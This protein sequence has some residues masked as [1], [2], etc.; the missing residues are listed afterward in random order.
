MVAYNDFLY[1]KSQ[2]GNTFGFEPIDIPDCMFDFQKALTEWAILKGR[3]AIFAD[4]GM[5]KTLMELVWADNVVRKTNGNVL[6]LTP[7]AVSSQTIEEAAKF[8]IEASRCQDGKH[9]RGIV[10]T[11][12]ERLGNFDPANFVGVVCDESSC[13]KAYAGKT[14]KVV[15]RFMSKLRFRL[16]GTAT[17]APNDYIELGTSSEA[18][19]ELSY[20]D[21]LRRFFAQLDD[22]GQK[23]ETRLQEEAETLISS[24]PSYYQKLAYRVSQTIGQWRLKHHAVQPFWRWVA[25]WAR[26]CRMPSD[27]GFDNGDFVL[28]PLEEHDHIIS[29]A[30]P[31]AGMLFTV[32]AIGMHE[33]R[34]ERKRTLTERCEFVAN[35][36]NHNRPAAIWCNTNDEGDL[37]ADIIPDAEQIAGKTSDDRRVELYDAFR[38]G[39]LKKL[40]IKAKIGAWGLNWQ[41]C[42]HVVNFATHSYEQYYQ[43]IRRCW[44]YPQKN[45]VRLDTIA[46]VGEVRVLGNM[47]A[48]AKRADAMFQHLVAEMNEAVRIER[49][50]LYTRK[51]EV[52][53]WL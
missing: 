50:N 47:R 52:P 22:K 13:I 19:G 46:T 10:I 27:L 23:K 16:L 37:L 24:D 39:E 4:C 20:S 25:S 18:L 35:L 48:K 51:V 45:A 29:P 3:A 17:A 40:V 5:G 2:I 12:Y 32:P 6:I 41:H 15:T 33:E 53:T 44:R 9:G 49:E 1:R 43:L 30:R 34:Q 8:G 42:N 21:M 26:A 31:P 28:P 38:S 11:N 36:V 14:R 7:L